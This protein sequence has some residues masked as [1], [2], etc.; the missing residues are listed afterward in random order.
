M[1][2]DTTL[3][4]V[5]LCVVDSLRHFARFISA[6]FHF[7]AFRQNAAAIPAHE[8]SI[9]FVRAISARHH[10]DVIVQRLSFEH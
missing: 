8:M 7:F 6:F 10:V 4:A 2:P 1:T 9:V 5:Q 3:P